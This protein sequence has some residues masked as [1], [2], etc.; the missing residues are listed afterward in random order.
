MVPPESRTSTR[1]TASSF[2]GLTAAIFRGSASRPARVQFPE[3]P[4][5]A[6]STSVFA[7]KDT[8]RVVRIT[9]LSSGLD[10]LTSSAK[11]GPLAF[12]L[13]EPRSKLQLELTG[14][15][16]TRGTAGGGG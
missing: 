16:A 11:P 9:R 3:R 15:G 6:I 4:V 2:I 1:L 7:R 8:R 13:H 10:A 12:A 14:V 5:K